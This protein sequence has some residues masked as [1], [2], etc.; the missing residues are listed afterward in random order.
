MKFQVLKIFT[1]S[2]E[3]RTIRHG[4]NSTHNCSPGYLPF[5]LLS[6]DYT[7]TSEK[8]TNEES[9]DDHFSFKIHQKSRVFF[10]VSPFKIFQSF[11][12][13]RNLAKH[14][15]QMLDTCTPSV[16]SLSPV[17]Q[18]SQ[19]IAT[20]FHFFKTDKKICSSKHK[21]EAFEF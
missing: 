4:L 9:F 6:Y 12:L 5:P 17:K 11:L 20:L 14:H 1:L 13:N 10:Y 16:I 3:M 18:Q 19:P 7:Y 8:L 15:S 2:F 21:P